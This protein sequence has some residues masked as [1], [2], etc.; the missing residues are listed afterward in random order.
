[1]PGSCPTVTAVCRILV[2]LLPRDMR[3]PALPCRAPTNA[4][5]GTPEKVRVLAYRYRRRQKLFHRFDA[6]EDD[7]FARLI[8]VG[9]NGRPRFIAVVRRTDLDEDY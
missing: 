5:P 6:L 3:G 8:A 9:R 2:R 7:R 4:L 1:M